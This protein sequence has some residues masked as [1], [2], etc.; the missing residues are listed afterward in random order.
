APR[1][2]EVP[3]FSTVTADWFDTIGLDAE[4]WYTNLRETVRFEEATTALVEQGH[5]VFV[6]T[7]AHPVLT[8]GV[9]ETLDAL[10]S[11]GI[12]LGTLRRDEGGLNR[13]FLSLG[14][15]HT[16]GVRVD[17]SGVFTGARQVDL[18]TYAFDHQR[19]WLTA[20]K[21]D[22]AGT[23]AATD[24]LDADF[25][26]AVER[27]DV[28]ALAET[29]DVVEQESLSAVLPLLSSWRRRRVEQ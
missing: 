21:A 10:D 8:L 23:A 4:Y 9:R 7:S 17:W 25:W 16:H 29:L 11:A 18:P 22:H 15:A 6:E 3:F 19:F 24:P 1:A 13:F 27:G 20:D 14:E 12:A 2:A 28:T 26:A 5:Q